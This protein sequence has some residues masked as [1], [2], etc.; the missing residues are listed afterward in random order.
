MSNAV[1]VAGA[2]ARRAH[3]T[4]IGSS[5]RKIPTQNQA[6]SDVLVSLV[7]A[8][9]YASTIAARPAASQTARAATTTHSRVPGAARCFAGDRWLSGDSTLAIMPRGPRPDVREA[10]CA[11][12]RMP[13]TPAGSRRFSSV[14][15]VSPGADRCVQVAGARDGVGPAGQLA[16]AGNAA[17]GQEVRQYPGELPGIS[18]VDQRHRRRGVGSA[19]ELG[20][21][22]DGGSDHPRTRGQ[23]LGKSEAERLVL[24]GRRDDAGPLEQPVERRL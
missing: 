6:N 18:R 13:R 2:V 1:R 4:A 14:G 24:A 23:P 7:W 11:A 10:G 19:G 17:G 8:T 9:W 12:G 3:S 20:V 16:G 15:Q 22:G 5:S 21:G